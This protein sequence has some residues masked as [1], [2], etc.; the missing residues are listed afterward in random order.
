MHSV[1]CPGDGDQDIFD[2]LQ[3]LGYAGVREG[4]I[5]GDRVTGW[6]PV[7][8]ANHQAWRDIEKQVA[9]SRQQVSSGRYSCLHYYMTINLMD[10]ALLAAYTGLCRWRV[11]L[12]LRPFFFQRLSLHHLRQY[13]ELFQVSVQDLQKG[14]L[15]PFP[16]KMNG[17]GATDGD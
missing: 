8:I 7:N 9:F 11:R 6:Q 12:H 14:V 10:P 5:A 1:D 3:V 16:Y 17:P 2:G 15:Q 4:H 13:A